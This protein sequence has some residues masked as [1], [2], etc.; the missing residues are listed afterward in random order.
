MPLAKRPSREDGQ[1]REDKGLLPVIFFNPA[2]T[3]G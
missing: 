3:V 2:V 1:P